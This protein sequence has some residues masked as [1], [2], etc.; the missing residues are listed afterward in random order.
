M[1]RVLKPD[2]DLANIIE[3]ECSKENWERI[4][5]RIWP[6]VKYLEVIVTGAMA[7]YIPV[8]DYYRLIAVGF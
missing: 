2:P 1:I 7:Q 3:S 8:L 4:V 6:N 5:T